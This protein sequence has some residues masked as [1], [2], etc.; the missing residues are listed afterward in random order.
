MR[1]LGD[2]EDLIGLKYGKLTVIMFAGIEQQGIQRPRNVFFWHCKCE[3][4]QT[5]IVNAAHLRRR[6]G[7]IKS[8]GCLR[9]RKSD[10]KKG[11]N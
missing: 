3:C 1:R 7:G 4:G 10:N 11:G 9:K 8:C 5:Q 6:K 2:T